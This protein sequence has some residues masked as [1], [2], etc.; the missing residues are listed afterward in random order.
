M[1]GVI[2]ATII[3][4]LAAAPSYACT[5]PQAPRCAVDGSF[6]SARSQ[7][8]C[9]KLM[10]VYHGQMEVFAQC[11]RDAGRDEQSALAELEHTLAEFNRRSRDLP[12]DD[13]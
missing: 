9:R 2:F 12:A 4:I 13:L 3:G 7:D 11:L 6:A 8:D 5:N 10:L 1:R